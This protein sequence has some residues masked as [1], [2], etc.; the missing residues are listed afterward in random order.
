MM[1][2][3]GSTVLSGQVIRMT[4]APA[5]NAK[6]IATIGRASDVPSA[7]NLVIN[8]DAAGG[9]CSDVSGCLSGTAI[10]LL[11]GRRRRCRQ[12][13]IK[14]GQQVYPEKLFFNNNIRS[15]NKQA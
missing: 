12:Y 9:R 13:K 11:L 2:V 15:D 14:Y 1:L 6:I 3:K 5:M 7:R 4:I 10:H 8:L